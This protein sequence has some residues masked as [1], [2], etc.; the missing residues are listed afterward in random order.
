MS[1]TGETRKHFADC[2]DLCRYV[3]ARSDGR[4]LLSFSCGKD[5]V[6]AY[7]QVRRHFREIELLYLE[8]VPGL[9][10]VEEAIAY[11]EK[12]FGQR[13]ARHPHPSLYRWINCGLYQTPE[14]FAAIDA[15]Q[16][17]N[18][19][20]DECFGWH[21]D[22]LGW[23]DTTFTGTG[24][25][26]A[27]S[28]NRRTSIKTH[29]PINHAR[30]SFFPVFD[31]SKGRL[32]DEIRA[33]GLKLSPEYKMFGRSFDGIDYRFIKPIKVHRPKDYALLLEWFPLLDAELYRYERR[34]D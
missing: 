8:L 24:V 5:A 19:D 22:D 1:S 10:F 9:S 29:G 14:R 11:Y 18:F 25:R 17:P 23:P 32:L 7:L 12:T 16:L 26:A 30:R 27:D 20:Y 6:G 3:S 13:I 34:A 33:A 15:L 31:W 2:D 21:R 4:V 28:L